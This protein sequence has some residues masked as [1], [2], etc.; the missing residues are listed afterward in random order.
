MTVKKIRT[1]SFKNRQ[2]VHLTVV[3]RQH[4]HENDENKPQDVYLIHEDG[5][6]IQIGSGRYAIV[7]LAADSASLDDA[8]SF[9]ALKFLKHDHDSPTFSKNARLRFYEELDKIRL[10]GRTDGRFVEYVGCSRIRAIHDPAPKE[11]AF[12][13]GKLGAAIQATA[14]TNEANC[15]VLRRE[16][17]ESVQGAFFAMRAEE[18]TLEEFLFYERPWQ[19]RTIFKIDDGLERKIHNLVLDA[20]EDVNEFLSE[21]SDGSRPEDCSGLEILNHIGKHRP[22]LRNMMV[23]ELFESVAASV[24]EVHSK[25]AGK[26]GS[27]YLAHRDIKLGNFLVSFVAEGKPIIR[28]S[29][30]GFVA[31]SSEARSMS[32]TIGLG[33]R[34]PVVLVPGSYLFRAPEQ[35]WPCDE[36]RFEIRAASNEIAFLD[37][38]GVNAEVGD[39]IE[40]QEVEFVEQREGTQG[41]AQHKCR[42]SGIRRQGPRVFVRFDGYRVNF[43][44]RDSEHYYVGYLIKSAGQHTDI[45]SLG[46]LLYFLATGGKNPEHF[47]LKCIEPSPH[48]GGA[49]DSADQEWLHPIFSTCF[50]LALSVS[51]DE[52]RS[53]GGDLEAYGRFLRDELSKLP[54]P[55][56]W[57][58]ADP[59]GVPMTPY[60]WGDIMR[61][62][63]PDVLD[64]LPAGVQPPQLLAKRKHPRRKSSGRSRKYGLQSRNN[65]TVDYYLRDAADN[66]LPFPVV[67]EVIRCMIR[68]K[69]DSYVRAGDASEA[70]CSFLDLDLHDR[71][72]ELQRQIT[73][74]LSK[75]PCAKFGLLDS[76]K[77]LGKDALTVL[78]TI[79][80]C[81]DRHGQAEEA[82]PAPSSRAPNP[83]AGSQPGKGEDRS[84][85]ADA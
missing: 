11:L 28:I 15:S 2:T 7:L 27:D 41:P 16:F 82:D 6:P 69:P 31:D 34:D 58:P 48:R 70:G 18:G 77:H 8:Q 19:Q 55:P 66:A 83:N 73:R 4:S 40:C 64:Y 63:R 33:V 62:V 25:P 29:D 12:E 79:R 54:S 47:Y 72:R 75:A 49:S 32:H 13:R 5:V 37:V 38:G 30:L 53:V 22:Q 20:R 46:C 74:I 14:T 50:G 10:F 60:N 61:E 35:M 9:Y 39:W 21:I 23:L 71:V 81:L 42:I 52:A 36:I 44:D 24:Q 26:T 84:M 59:N 78:F 43:G 67:Y 56:D 45:F 85:T 57:S 17:L 68:G 3:Q 1:I 76:Y 80:M 65:P 51:L